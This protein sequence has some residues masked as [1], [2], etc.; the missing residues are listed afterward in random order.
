MESA[1]ERNKDIT[2]QNTTTTDVEPIVSS[3]VGY[4]TF[5]SSPFTSMRNSVILAQSFFMSR[6]PR[7]FYATRML[8]G[9]PGLEPGPSVLETDM[10][11]IDTMPLH[12]FRPSRHF[13]SL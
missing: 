2:K 9:A 6:A 11:A 7:P 12:D 3:R 8:A 4:E 5:F 1:I 10:L 13:T